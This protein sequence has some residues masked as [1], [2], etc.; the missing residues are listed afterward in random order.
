MPNHDACSVNAK[1]TVTR[2][3][4]A[5]W[6]QKMCHLKGYFLSP[7]K[8]SFKTNMSDSSLYQQTSFLPT[9]VKNRTNCCLWVMP[10]CSIVTPDEVNVMLVFSWEFS[11]SWLSRCLWQNK[12][13]RIMPNGA[14]Q[15]PVTNGVLHSQIPTSTWP[16]IANMCVCVPWNSRGVQ[17]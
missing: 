13:G 3:Q 6:G 12:P 16:C 14:Q 7:A 10:A 1:G 8:C 17:S 2:R 15:P 11:S 9:V 4:I 5:S